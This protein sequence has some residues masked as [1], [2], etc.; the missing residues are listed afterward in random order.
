MLWLLFFALGLEA[1]KIKELVGKKSYYQNAIVIEK[2]FNDTMSYPQMIQKLEALGIRYIQTPK[3]A[4]VTF[5]FQTKGRPLLA[6]Y[7]IKKL[8]KVGDIQ[9]YILSQ[10]KKEGT[11]LSVLTHHHAKNR[12]NL[13]RMVS[14]LEKEGVKIEKITQESPFHFSYLLDFSNAHFLAKALPINEEITLNNKRGRYLFRIDGL[15]SLIEINAQAG[16]NWRPKIV[17][18][19]EALRVVDLFSETTKKIQHV[20][21]TLDSSVR[22]I[23]ISDAFIKENI[24]NGLKLLAR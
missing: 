18:Y 2:A 10:T 5:S 21:L 17:L 15:V 20:E 19:D 23:E 12:F 3:D 9:E 13:K 1:S 24:K 8:H 14:F 7:S 22:Y 16:N 6:L 11:T 4:E